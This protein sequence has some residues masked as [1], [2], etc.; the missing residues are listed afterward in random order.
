MFL[1]MNFDLELTICVYDID[2]DSNLPL[3]KQTRLILSQ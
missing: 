1:I 3:F 2:N